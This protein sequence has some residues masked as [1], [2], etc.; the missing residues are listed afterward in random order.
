[1]NQVNSRSYPPKE[2]VAK[3]SDL[4]HSKVLS[5]VL[6]KR[7]VFYLGEKVSEATCW[8]ITIG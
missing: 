4:D 7:A 1:M 2:G 6:L 8:G 3:L 5:K